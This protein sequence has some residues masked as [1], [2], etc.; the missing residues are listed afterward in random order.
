MNKKVVLAAITVISILVVSVVF[1]LYLE[2]QT[3][4]NPTNP[5]SQYLSFP[6]GKQSK[7]SLLSA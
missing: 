4:P 2:Y 5:A 3:R 1:G 6:D 7:I